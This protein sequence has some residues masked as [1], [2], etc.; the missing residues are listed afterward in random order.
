MK[1]KQNWD[2]LSNQESLPM[3]D[4]IGIA[5]MTKRQFRILLLQV[6]FPKIITSIKWVIV[7]RAESQALPQDLP[8]QSLQFHKIPRWSLWTSKFENH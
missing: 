2:E 6:W 5:E 1:T 4:I 8:N 7:P 3:L